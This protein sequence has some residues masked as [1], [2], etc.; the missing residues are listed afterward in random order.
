VQRLGS[1]TSNTRTPDQ[2]AAA[3]FQAGG[4][5]VHNSL[6]RNVATNHPLPL[7]QS[8][9]LFALGYM[10]IHDAQIQVF[11]SKYT[12]NFWRPITAIQN[13]ASD[14]NPDTTADGSWSALLATPPHPDYPAAHAEESA[15]VIEV[16]KSIHGDAIS[17]TVLPR[18]FA[19]PSDLLRETMDSR[20]WAGAHFRTACEAGADAGVKIARHAIENFLRP[21]P[22]L[23]TGAPANPGEFQL[24]F[25]T[26]PAVSHVVERSS[27]FVQWTPAQTNSYGLF[28]YVDPGAGGADQRFYRVTVR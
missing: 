9:R 5:E 19:S 8:A 22:T 25:T 14:G 10:T 20:I 12:Y 2:T 15:A 4:I 23:M 28:Q 24:S 16:I 3:I 21:V 1:A 13:G 11:D 27:D 18:T 17:I 26:G 7:V 6:L